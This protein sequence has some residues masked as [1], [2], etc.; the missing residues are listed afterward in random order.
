MRQ[1]FA[2]RGRCRLA[3][4][5]CLAASTLAACSGSVPSASPEQD[6]ALA[7]PSASDP[8]VVADA[9]VVASGRLNDDLPA[10][11]R[12][13]VIAV[14][15]E[16]VSADP[17]RVTAELERG[18]GGDSALRRYAGAM[19]DTGRGEA[20][21]RQMALVLRGGDPQADPHRVLTRSEEKD[22]SVWFPVAEDAGFFAGAVA[23][24]LETSSDPDV[25][26]AGIASGL[27]T[28]ELPDV[29][30]AGSWS[31]WVQIAALS[32]DPSRP[33]VGTPAEQAFNARFRRVTQQLE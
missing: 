24:A 28:P 18:L 22:G 33:D 26:A 14:L 23:M 6:A 9:F 11:E 17:A 12:D 3:V 25:A 8:A 13:E 10:D 19:L 29:E 30:V 21:G 16:A 27:G 5:V 15:A 7:D 31:R 32:P 1:S 2:S 20:L 4:A